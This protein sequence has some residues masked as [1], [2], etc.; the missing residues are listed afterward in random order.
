MMNKEMNEQTL[1]AKGEELS[2]E[3]F[4]T[5]VVNDEGEREMAH[6]LMAPARNDRE[7]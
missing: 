2:G 7:K 3:M 5:L 4:C 6:T 1:F